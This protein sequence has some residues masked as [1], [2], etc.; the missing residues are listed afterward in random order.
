MTAGIP[1][2]GFSRAN[3]N[4][5]RFIDA[6]NFLFLEFLRLVEATKPPVA[7]IE[8]VSALTSHSEGFFRDEIVTGLEELDYLVKWRI[9]DASA[10]GVPQRR[11][12]VFFVGVQPDLEFNWPAPSHGGPNQSAIRNVEQA[13]LISRASSQARQP[14]NTTTN[15]TTSTRGFSAVSKRSF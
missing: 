9:L 6:R 10:Y 4:R 5:N 13:I 8:N 12:R 3:R 14:T 7:I 1:C 11:R 15:R 2:E